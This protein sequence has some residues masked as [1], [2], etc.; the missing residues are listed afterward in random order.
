MASNTDTTLAN[1]LYELRGGMQELFATDFPFLSEITGIGDPH[2]VGRYTRAM[3]A[4]R[5]IY[6]GSNVRF[7]LV[8][9]G[10]ASGGW[11]AE[12]G[13]WNVPSALLTDKAT[14]TLGRFVQPFSVTVDAERDTMSNSDIQAVTLLMDQA[15]KAV[16][17][18]EEIAFLGDGTGLMGTITDSAT[19]LATTITGGNWDILLPGS[20]WDVLTRSSG[21]DPGSGLR[22]KIA[23]VSETSDSAGTITWSTTATASDGGS[24]SITHASTEGIYPPGSYGNM[25]QGLT[26]ARGVTGTFEGVTS[27]DT[28]PYWIGTDGRN[29]VTTTLAFSGAMGKVGVR[30]GRRWGVGFWDYAIGDP[31]AIDL[32]EEGLYNQLRYDAQTMTLKSGHTGIIFAGADKPF[33]MLKSPFHKKASI[34]FVRNDFMQLYGDQKGP[35]FLQ[36]DGAIFRRFSRTLAKEAD[37]LDRPQLAFKSVNGLVFFANPRRKSREPRLHHERS[38]SA[39]RLHQGGRWRDRTHAEGV[40]QEPAPASPVRGWAAALGGLVRPRPRPRGCVRV[41]L[42]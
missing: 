10:M 38:W 4:N 24:G 30:R 17:R 6:S 29:G 14:V 21:A 26:Q 33:P 13:T 34:V 8:P 3:D 40:R 7:S 18:N 1:V 23:S 31:A 2:S 12:E 16:A 37:L 32:Y 42:D 11:V 19:S 22:R 36:D 5:E 20:V 41:R 25:V 28:K 35:D 9:Y 27:R 15:S 39:G